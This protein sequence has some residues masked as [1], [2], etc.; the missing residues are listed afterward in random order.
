M[1]VKT[2]LNTLT[3]E[4]MAT[5]ILR[6]QEEKAELQK[7]TAKQDDAI[8]SLQR[9]VNW[10]TNVLW[11]ARSE[12][13]VLEHLEPEEQLLLDGT[14]LN[15]PKEPPPDSE[16]VENLS[17]GRK[18]NTKVTDKST[19]GARFDENVP[20]IEVPVE[21]PNIIGVEPENLT[22]L[23]TRYSDRIVALPP[24]ARLR[25]VIQTTKNELTGDVSRPEVPKGV[26]DQCCA[27]VS[28][29]AKLV[30]DKFCYHLPLYRQHK[31]L[32][33]NGVHINR[34]TLSRYIH[35]TAELLEPIYDA[36]L[37]SILGSEVISM[38]ETPVKAGRPEGGGKMKTGFFWPLYGNKDEIYFLFAPTRSA[39]VVKDVLDGFQGTLLSDGYD[40]YEKFAEKV[41]GL[42]WAACWAHTR[43]KFIEA[44][45][46]EPREVQKILLWMQA[47]YKVEKDA[48]DDRERRKKLRAEISQDKVDE[49]FKYFNT[50]LA[51]STLPDSSPFIQAIKYALNREAGLR[52][53]LSNPDVPIDNNHTER[54]IRPVAIGRKNWLFNW[55]KQG[56]RYSAILY[57]LISSCRLQKID[58]MT[59][60]V[61][62]L[63]RI[64]THPA[65]DTHLL[66]PRNW[67][68][69]FASEPLGSIASQ[70]RLGR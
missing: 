52:V 46:L 49:I 34:G 66:T 7:R 15:L 12:R 2:L 33:Q 11:G 22:V 47:L 6:E 50:T 45:E 51:Q 13:R 30:T 37:S 70:L 65:A 68:E 36:V 26:W 14:M 60:L 58:P 54:E 59:Y 43:R 32:E 56:A 39:D 57:T 31:E 5:I 17:N 63:Q 27:D 38:D 3:P 61:D 25:M 41:D 19:G 28:F 44:E 16:T 4:E 10:L 62:I 48:G 55:T 18:N 69:N 35:R 1:D 40:V 8:A 21:D 24:F 67:K 20:T 64:Q 23:E 53:F 29:L 9:H 42:I